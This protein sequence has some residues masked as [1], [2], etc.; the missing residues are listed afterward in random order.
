MA[1][2]SSFFDSINKDRAY[3]AADF[4]SHMA[5]YF[6]N[7]VFN[8]GLKVVTNND[9]SISIQLGSANINGYKYKLDTNP[10]IIKVANADGILNRIDNI[11]IRLDIPNRQITAEIINGDFAENAVA[12]VLSRGTSIYDLRIAKINVPAGTTTITTD[13]IEDTRFDDSDC[14][15]VICAV[16]SPDFTDVL[17]Q[18]TALWDELLKT[19]KEDFEKWFDKMKG[20]LSEDSAGKLQLQIDDLKE[21]QVTVDSTTPNKGRVWLK[22]GKNLINLIYCKIT[23]INAISQW[24]KNNITVT[25]N[26][27]WGNAL[28]EDFDVEIG[29]SYVFSV[30]YVN[31][32]SSNTG[33]I[34]Y[35]NNDETLN[36]KDSTAQSGRFEVSFTSNTN[37]V[38]IKFSAN[39]TSDV[40]NNVVTYTNVQLEKG[41]EVTAFEDYINQEIYCKNGD[42]WEKFAKEQDTGWIDMSPYVDTEH[43]APRQG[44]PPMARKIG[45]VVYWM[46]YVYC[47]K[48]VGFNEA[49]IMINL[50]DWAQNKSSQEFARGF[51]M[52]GS[53]NR[54]VMYVGID[55][56]IGQ[57]SNIQNVGE[58]SWKAYSLATISGYISKGE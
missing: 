13:L 38:K 24:Q 18:Y 39:N 41:T 55:I 50:P 14:G 20:Q 10:K 46:G 49:N 40:R 32:E 34:I 25:S 43:F 47:I 1:E 31:S 3:Y 35:N 9:M 21:K 23:N 29:K 6:T 28:I 11:V 57:E 45:K 2:K 44:L 51:G 36:F 7:G 33:I 42:D 27:G 16:Q 58:E 52:W 17:T 19:E 12:P 54:G 8:N 4:A 48:D 56:R 37:K 53:W 26:G 30:D 5:E 15:N 22:K